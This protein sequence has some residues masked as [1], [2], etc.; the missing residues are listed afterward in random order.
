MN[1]Q[2]YDQESHGSDNDEILTSQLPAIHLKAAMLPDMKGMRRRYPLLPHGILETTMEI[3]E[4][5]HNNISH[6][7]L[8]LDT[9]SMQRSF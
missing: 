6:T 1:F 3:D 5:L 7:D 8:N 2:H 9:K 4:I